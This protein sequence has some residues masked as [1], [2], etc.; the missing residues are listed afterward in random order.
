[1]KNFKVGHKKF[2]R[3]GLMAKY[4]IFSLQQHCYMVDLPVF[5]PSK[6]IRGDGV[7]SGLKTSKEIKRLPVKKKIK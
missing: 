1:M 7:K 4:Y 2:G 3:Y 6:G 5:L